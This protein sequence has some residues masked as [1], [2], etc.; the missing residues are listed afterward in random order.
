MA[1]WESMWAR[2]L[3][4]GAAFDAA[5]AEPALT[6]LLERHL[7]PTGRA[8]VPGCGRAYA[9]VALA[10]AE[11]TALGI[12]IAPTGVKAAQALI[13]EQVPPDSPLA[14]RVTAQEA[15]FFAS[16]ADSLGGQ[17]DLIYDCTFL[18]AIQPH[19]REAW[20]AKTSELLAP[21][22][23]VVTL[24]FPLGPLSDSGPPFTINEELVQRL[25][26]PHGLN[27]LSCEDVPKDMLA[28]G[29]MSGEKIARWGRAAPSQG[30][31][32]RPL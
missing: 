24:I 21:A 15:D 9:A 11:R 6:G 1:G 28:R 3:P 29:S 2:G 31:L 20:A 12:D 25:L 10:S 7:L 26:A 18:C 13:T 22:G 23:E 14:G 8:L 4:K 30:S 27:C 32:G 5:Q 17:F 19:Q 16:T